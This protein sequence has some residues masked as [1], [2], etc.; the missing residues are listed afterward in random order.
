MPAH[1][2]PS[3]GARGAGAAPGAA[4]AV[5]SRLTS[6]AVQAATQVTELSVAFKAYEALERF[7]SPEYDHQVDDDV[8]P[9]RAQLGALLHTLNAEMLQQINALADVTTVLQ[10]Q[11]D[12]KAAASSP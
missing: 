1:H 4:H 2:T 10:A 3:R 5:H 9:S 6:L 12:S 7:I 8:P 11:L